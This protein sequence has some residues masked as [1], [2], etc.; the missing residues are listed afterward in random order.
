MPMYDFQCTKCQHV[1]EE[2]TKSDDPPPA[3]P[4][5]ASPSERQIS[6]PFLSQGLKQMSRKGKKFEKMHKERGTKPFK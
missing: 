2:I 5:C 1:F 6:T 3:C 4:E